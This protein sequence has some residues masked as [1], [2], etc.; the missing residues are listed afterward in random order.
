MLV[1][2]VGCSA[3]VTICLS[4]CAHFRSHAVA[5]EPSKWNSVCFESVSLCNELNGAWQCGQTGNKGNYNTNWLVQSHFITHI[6][7]K[8]YTWRIC[9]PRQPLAANVI[10]LEKCCQHRS[11]QLFRCRIF[12]VTL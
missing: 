11:W 1:C 3:F 10:L 8:C 6:S 12:L 4:L 9:S 7:I 2:L 5:A